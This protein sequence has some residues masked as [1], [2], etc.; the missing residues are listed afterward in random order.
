MGISAS[1]QTLFY[2]ISTTYVGKA[3]THPGLQVNFW[4]EI[5]DTTEEAVNDNETTHDSVQYRY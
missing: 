2:E 1:T 4:S 5:G 3:L